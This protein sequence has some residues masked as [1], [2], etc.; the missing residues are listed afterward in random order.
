QNRDE[1]SWSHVKCDSLRVDPSTNGA[2]EHAL[3]PGE[4]RTRSPRSKSLRMHSLYSD[5]SA[6]ALSAGEDAHVRGVDSAIHLLRGGAKF[7]LGGL[8][9][10]RVDLHAAGCAEAEVGRGAG[11][12]RVDELDAQIAIIRAGGEDADFFRANED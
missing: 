9:R 12:D 2:A 5:R 10:Q 8:D 7:A 3:T 4:V 1:N 6:A 11:E